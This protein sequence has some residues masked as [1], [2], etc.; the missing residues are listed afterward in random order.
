MRR[1]ARLRP[2]ET[3]DSTAQTQYEEGVRLRYRGPAFLPRSAELFRSAADAGHAVATAWLAR[4]YFHAEG[5]EKNDVEAQRLATVALNERK[6]REVADQGDP[7]AQC[8]LGCLYYDG[9]GVA[10]D[11]SM[12]VAWIRKAAEQNHPEGLTCLAESFRDGDGVD[13]DLATALSYFHR[14][15]I[16][17]DSDG[18]N[19]LGLAYRDGQGT[20]ENYDDAAFWFR[21]SADQGNAYSQFYLAEAF[22]LGEVKPPEGNVSVRHHRLTP[23]VF[24]GRGPRRE[25]GGGVVPPSRQSWPRTCEAGPGRVGH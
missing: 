5:V 15:A 19:S 21:K 13:Q 11:F 4:C 24:A 25:P 16:L 6:L 3:H 20:D 2:S 22:V 7:S 10:K 9:H 8:A 17:G 18:Q 14:A 12:S 23:S 1:S